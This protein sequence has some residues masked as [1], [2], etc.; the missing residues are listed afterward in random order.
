[1]GMCCPHVVKVNIALGLEGLLPFE[2]TGWYSGGLRYWKGN[3]G[4]RG[5]ASLDLGLLLGMLPI[6]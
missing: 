1:M 6:K 3:A 4:S 2:P 5:T